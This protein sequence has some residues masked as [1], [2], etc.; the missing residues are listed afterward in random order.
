[1]MNLDYVIPFSDHC[2]HSELLEVV[3]QCNPRKIYTFHG[4][5]EE[6]ANYLVN[7]GYDAESINRGNKKV[8]KESMRLQ[9]T[10]SL[11]IYF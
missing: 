9:K 5:Q 11:D 8:R 4:F 7:L 3:K 6:F 10:K 2:D 1:M